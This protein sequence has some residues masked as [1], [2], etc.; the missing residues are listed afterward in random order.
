MS[1]HSTLLQEH[2]MLT[3]SILRIPLTV[4]FLCHSELMKIRV[5]NGGHAALCYPSALLG[6]KYVHNAMEHPVVS[7]F[8][9]KLERTEIVPTVPPVPDT[10]VEEYWDIIAERFSNPTINDTIE[11]NCYDG[12]SRQPKFIVPV[13]ASA[14]KKIGTEHC[15]DGL[16]MVSAMWCR[17]CQGTTEAGES[18]APNAPNWDKLQETAMKA[19]EDPCIWLSGNSDVYGPLGENEIFRSAFEKALKSIEENGVEGAMKMYIE[20]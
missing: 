1:T 8:L 9:D 7:K 18:I 5:L 12:S 11:R 4:P 14:V 17:Y 6:L 16:A 2:D 19:K 15:V 13:A 10:D 3:L 20:S